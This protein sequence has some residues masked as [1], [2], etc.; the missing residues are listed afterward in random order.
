MTKWSLRAACCTAVYWCSSQLAAAPVV[1]Y[2]TVDQANSNPARVYPLDAYSLGKHPLSCTLADGT[3]VPVIVVLDAAP[4]TFLAVRS[5]QGPAIYANEGRI[6][7]QPLEYAVFA[8]FREC[9]MHNLI[10]VQATNR[11]EASAYDRR[12]SKAADCLAVIPTQTTLQLSEGL[13]YAQIVPAL[14]EDYGEQAASSANELAR[15]VDKDYTSQHVR[16][17]VPRPGG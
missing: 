2:P 12:I 15:C 14:R 5:Q 8:F 13:H 17:L 11:N 1:Q 6:R 16:Q 7:K 3:P 9:G 10:T 4:F